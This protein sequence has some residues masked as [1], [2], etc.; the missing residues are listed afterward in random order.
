MSD[1]KEVNKDALEGMDEA[2]SATAFILRR[3]EDDLVE[4]EGFFNKLV[5]QPDGSVYDR[6][7][8]C[9]DIVIGVRRLVESELHKLEEAG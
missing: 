7:R 4:F 8:Y 1:Y 2:L 9:K 3:A 6:V 5:G